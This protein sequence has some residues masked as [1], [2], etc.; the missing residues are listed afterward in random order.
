MIQIIFEN[1]ICKKVNI[2]LENEKL[3]NIKNYIEQQDFIKNVNTEGGTGLFKITK[4]LS[5]DLKNT[6]HKIDFEITNDYYFKIWIEIG[7]GVKTLNEKNS[8]N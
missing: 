5:I 4:I 1:K 7:I 6:N 3:T 2:R 8:Y